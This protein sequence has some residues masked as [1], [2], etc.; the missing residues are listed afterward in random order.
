MG[1]RAIPQTLNPPTSLTLIVPGCCSAQCSPGVASWD[2]GLEFRV[3]DEGELSFRGLGVRDQTYSL[4]TL[5]MCEG[6]GWRCRG[7]LS[8][9]SG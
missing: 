1:F 5:T 9:R 7:S 6:P 4:H 8:L 3:W 2:E